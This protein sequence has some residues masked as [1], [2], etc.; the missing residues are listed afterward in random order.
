MKCPV[1]GKSVGVG[2]VSGTLIQHETKNGERCAGTGQ[3]PVVAAPR[4]S[5]GSG[6][7]SAAASRARSSAGSASAER[8]KPSTGTSVTG[9]GSGAG[10]S[11]ATA[12]Q[13]APARRGVTVRK[14]EVNQEW[15]KAREEKQERLRLEREDRARARN[16]IYSTGI[17]EEGADAPGDGTTEEFTGE[18][19]SKS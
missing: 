8:Y 6:S 16:E 19:S 4:A 17:G 10:A 3:A 5:G 2:L 18:S 11:A 14:V 15:L 13:A 12:R 1:C 9:A 7:G